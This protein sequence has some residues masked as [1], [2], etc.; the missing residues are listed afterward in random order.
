MDKIGKMSTEK[1]QKAKKDYQIFIQLFSN[2]KFLILP[3]GSN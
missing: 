3:K 2:K 1:Q